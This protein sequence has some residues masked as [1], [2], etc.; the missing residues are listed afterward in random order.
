VECIATCWDSA[1]DGI[2]SDEPMRKPTWIDGL[3]SGRVA[4]DGSAALD[5]REMIE[6][7]V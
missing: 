6:S 3:S 7:A 2:A 5:M 4:F 1:A